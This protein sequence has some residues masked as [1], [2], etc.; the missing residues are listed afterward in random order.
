M[1]MLHLAD[2]AEVNVSAV[3]RA[4]RGGN[5]KLSTWIKL[6]EGLGYR[7]LFDVVETS[8]EMEGWHEEEAMNRRIR[9][10]SPY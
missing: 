5:A 9:R 8:E 10:G 4:E 3:Q 1:P 7:L 6:F 2:V